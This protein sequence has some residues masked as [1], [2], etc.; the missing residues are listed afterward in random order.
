MKMVACAEA[1]EPRD[2][3]QEGTSCRGGTPNA[4]SLVSSAVKE[5]SA[6]QG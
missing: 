2:P 3:S 4:C 6:E 5:W 1:V